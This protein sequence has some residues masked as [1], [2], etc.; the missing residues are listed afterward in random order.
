M[1]S[2]TSCPL[3]PLRHDRPGATLGVVRACAF[4]VLLAGV[5]GAAD[6]R[7]AGGPGAPAAAKASDKPDGAELVR[8]QDVI[9]LA[10][11]HRIL[12]RVVES[13]D[14]NKIAI[15]TGAGVIRLPR[16]EVVDVQR[17]LAN[18]MAAV[19]EKPDDL[20]LR[21]ETA[22]WCRVSSYNQ[23]AFDLLAPVTDRDDLDV[24]ALGLF[25][26]LTDKLKSA[27]EALPV[28]KRYRDRGGTDRKHLDRL[29]ILESAMARW[30]ASRSDGTVAVTQTG[31]PPAG[32]ATSAVA[33]TALLN[34]AAVVA[35][36]SLSSGLEIRNGQ[37]AFIAEQVQWSN[38]VTI[39]VVAVG[40]GGDRRPMLQVDFTGG[41]KGKAT[42]ERRVN[43]T[44][45]D[46]SVLGFY[47]AN[48][49]DKPLRIA[50]ALKTGTAWDY[51]E[52][53]QEVIAP[54]NELR[55]VRIDL[56]GDR[57][58]SQA[59]NWSANGTIKGLDEIKAIQLQIYNGEQAGS[60]LVG[61]MGFRRPGSL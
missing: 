12:G 2:L 11:R 30:E 10:N 44:I 55:E 42:V 47:I 34:P 41:D 17:S 38:P 31:P 51:Y 57:F 21:V 53:P 45:T 43:W 28:Y 15:N 50:L 26:F 6:P 25:A 8:T 40:A 35:P 59:T 1:P 23:E 54:G 27:K 16:S 4:L 61:G 22:R 48:Q 49:T 39:A 7:P 14:P 46:D 5:A 58:K 29:A 33:A 52:G 20:A 18:R 19:D 60:I 3:E 56:K 9:I 32:P 13:D 24:E 37:S 36:A